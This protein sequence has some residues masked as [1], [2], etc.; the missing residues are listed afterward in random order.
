M[1][2][3]PMLPGE[4]R[5]C[6]AAMRWSQ[7]EFAR[8]LDIPEAKARRIVRGEATMQDR[9][10]VWLRNVSREVAAVYERNPPPRVG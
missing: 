8:A 1:S 3:A 7:S 5:A 2:A 4:I 9:A 6:L 10:A